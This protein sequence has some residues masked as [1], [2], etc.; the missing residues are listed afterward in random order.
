LNSRQPGFH[1]I[2]PKANISSREKR[3]D[4]I[5]QPGWGNKEVVLGAISPIFRCISMSVSKEE[6]RLKFSGIGLPGFVQV[7][8]IGEIAMVRGEAYR[9]ACSF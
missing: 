4:I 3:C 1:P 5:G 8:E 7:P 9:V 2:S 6:E